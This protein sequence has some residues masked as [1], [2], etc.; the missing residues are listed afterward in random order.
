M[1]KSKKTQDWGM[2]GAFAMARNQV[3]GDICAAALLF[4]LKY[5]WDHCKKKLERHGNEWVA[6][7]RSNWA[8]E[9]GLS[10]GEMKNRALPRLRKCGFVDIRQMKLT[11]DGPKL[12]WMRLDEGALYDETEPWDMYEPKL[13]GMKGIGNEGWKSAYAYKRNPDEILE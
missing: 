9:A 12:L 11:P 8:R 2:P 6:M 4:R 3:G 13:N 1:A 10:E 7:S 5:R